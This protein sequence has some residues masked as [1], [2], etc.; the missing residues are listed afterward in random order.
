MI[1]IKE[2]KRLEGVVPAIILP[3]N[4]DGQVNFQL[5]KR[6]IEYLSAAGANGFFVNGTTGKAFWLTNEEKV[7]IYK[8]A[9]NIHRKD[10]LYGIIQ[11][12]G[13]KVIPSIKAGA[14]FFGRSHKWIKML[15]LTLSRKEINQAKYIMQNI[16]L[17]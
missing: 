16:D 1:N 12:T 10:Q 4:E 15:L 3:L 11:V 8:V 14:S 7:E 6:Q 9:N 2:N 17:L 5:L 13:I